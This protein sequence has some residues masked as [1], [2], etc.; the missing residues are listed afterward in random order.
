MTFSNMMFECP[1]VT[2]FIALLL[3]LFCIGGTQEGNPWWTGFFSLY[4]VLFVFMTGYSLALTL[5]MFSPNT[6]VDC[7]V[8]AIDQAEVVRNRRGAMRTVGN[9]P[10]VLVEAKQKKKGTPPDQYIVTYLFP[11]NRPTVKV[12]QPCAVCIEKGVMGLRMIR[13]RYEGKV[14][15]TAARL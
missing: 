12:G 9:I 13:F 2:G 15:R 14:Y 4:G 8:V 6:W 10:V 7:K 11:S 5:Q 3:L 1:F